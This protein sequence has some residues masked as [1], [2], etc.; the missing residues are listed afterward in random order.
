MENI[1]TGHWIF[2]GVFVAFFITAIAFAYRKDLA[3]INQHYSKIWL[4]IL[5]MAIVYITILQLN[6]FT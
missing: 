6:R 3:R 2:A 5:I 4:L 1:T